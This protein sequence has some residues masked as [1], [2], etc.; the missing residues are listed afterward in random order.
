MTGRGVYMYKETYEIN[1][2]IS[3]RLY[4]NTRNYIPLGCGNEVTGRTQDLIF[5]FIPF[6]Y[7]I[8]LK[9]RK[10]VLLCNI[11]KVKSL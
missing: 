10:H 2:N 7:H 1:D 8:I 6:M 4:K 9:N 11:K 3:E 5:H